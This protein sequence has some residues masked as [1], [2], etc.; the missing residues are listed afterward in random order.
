MFPKGWATGC[1]LQIPCLDC[2]QALKCYIR[3]DSV[4]HFIDVFRLFW[5]EKPK[6]KHSADKSGSWSGF[7]SLNCPSRLLG[8]N[9]LAVAASCLCDIWSQ[10][11]CMCS[12]LYESIFETYDGY[13]KQSD[14]LRSWLLLLF[15]L[16]LSHYSSVYLLCSL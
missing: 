12:T 8:N 16:D 10:T 15:L 11:F 2:L 1:F 5:S 4:L 3:W 9:I 6:R 14:F 13:G 7:W